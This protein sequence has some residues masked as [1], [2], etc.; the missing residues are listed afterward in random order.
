MAMK[1]AR[2]SKPNYKKGVRR[3]IIYMLLMNGAIPAKAIPLLSDNPETAYRKVL[4]ME[5]EGLIV[6]DKY[7]DTWLITFKAFTP[8]LADE[9]SLHFPKEAIETYRNYGHEAAK[10]AKF[11]EKRKRS[12]LV[13]ERTIEKATTEPNDEWGFE[14]YSPEEYVEPIV[15]EEGDDDD[16]VIDISPTPLTEKEKKAKHDQMIRSKRSSMRRVARNGETLMFIDGLPNINYTLDDKPEFSSPEEVP[17]N[18]IFYTP[19]ELNTAAISYKEGQKTYKFQGAR[20]NGLL[21]SEGGSYI[22]Y[23]SSKWGMQVNKGFEQVL[24]S[25]VNSILQS[26]R[27]PYV[28]GCIRLVSNDR[29]VLSLMEMK[30]LK[31]GSYTERNEEDWITNIENYFKKVYVLPLDSTGQALASIMCTKDWQ[32]NM[33]KAFFVGLQKGHENCKIELHMEQYKNTHNDGFMVYYNDKAGTS[34]HHRTI[35]LHY[36][37]PDIK[38]LRNFIAA[39]KK[40]GTTTE[41]GKF[42]ADDLYEIYCF[43]FQFP[44][45]KTYVGKYAKI[46]KL[47]FATFY[48]EYLKNLSSENNEK[49]Q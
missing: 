10:V 13:E 5:K 40:K 37:I 47:S 19:Y 26:H 2:N 18:N 21:V 11:R 6:R 48:K 24:V 41:D 39:I 33:T 49:K 46:K 25:Y 32:T 38:K 23:N 15:I 17:L 7:Q 31:I 43:D 3:K 16:D 12:P 44:V 9:L 29:Q 45:L 4:E 20:H 1:N 36:F 14:E 8:D 34:V 22:F 35:S 28:N 42:E 27:L 30:T